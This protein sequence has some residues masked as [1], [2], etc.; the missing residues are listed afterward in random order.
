MS[1]LACH[2]E[3]EG[4]DNLP[5]YLLQ[6]LVK[7]SSAAINQTLAADLSSP[8]GKHVVGVVQVKSNIGRRS[9]EESRSVFMCAQRCGPFCIEI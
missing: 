6:D 1:A 7:K 8:S 9:R 4:T 3:L 2:S 5:N